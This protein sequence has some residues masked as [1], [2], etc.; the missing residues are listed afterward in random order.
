MNTVQRAVLGAANAITTFKGPCRE[1]EVP[2]S[3]GLGKG[4]PEAQVGKESPSPEQAVTPDHSR[5]HGHVVGL[6]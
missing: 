2:Q 6:Q 1:E 5:T 4:S 3:A